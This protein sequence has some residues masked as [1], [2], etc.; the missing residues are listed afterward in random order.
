MMTHSAA[1]RPTATDGHQA[2]TGDVPSETR[3]SGSTPGTP[4]SHCPTQ[5]EE[6]GG[7]ATATNTAHLETSPP[8]TAARA[9]RTQSVRS[10]IMRCVRRVRAHRAAR[11]Q[12]LAGTVREKFW[13]VSAAAN[14]LRVMV[15]D[16]TETSLTAT[17]RV[18]SR[19]SSLELLSTG[20][21]RAR[22]GGAAANCVS[23]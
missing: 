15:M 19:R 12:H 23:M 7:T 3:S 16:F 4:W 1:R 11:W 10:A 8:R 17:S 13:A 18:T 21:R 20:T 5:S 22:R 6:R 14:W 9:P 2:D